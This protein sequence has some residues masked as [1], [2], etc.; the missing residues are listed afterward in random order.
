MDIF[1]ADFVGGQRCCIKSQ[2]YLYTPGPSEKEEEKEEQGQENRQHGA[3]DADDEPA[4]DDANAKNDAGQR[5]EHEQHAKY[6]TDDAANA[7]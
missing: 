1:N 5:N 4:N 3:D 2:G 6:G 7:G